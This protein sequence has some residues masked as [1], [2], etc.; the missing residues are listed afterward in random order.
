MVLVYKIPEGG[1][2]IKD[3]GAMKV[4]YIQGMISEFIYSGIQTRFAGTCESQTGIYKSIYQALECDKNFQRLPNPLL[5]AHPP[6]FSASYTFF[7]DKA[8]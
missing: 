7:M 4:F 3:L 6:E 8:G 2:L 1:Q 5:T